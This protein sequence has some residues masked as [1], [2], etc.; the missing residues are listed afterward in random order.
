MVTG[1]DGG[2]WGPA[3]GESN[4]LLWT[5]N[6]D[7]SINTSPQVIGDYPRIVYL[8]AL[9]PN[10]RQVFAVDYN[11]ESIDVRSTQ[12]VL[13]NNIGDLN[14]IQSQ[15][16]DIPMQGAFGKFGRPCKCFSV[17]FS[18]NGRQIVAGF[19]LAGAALWDLWTLQEDY[20]FKG[21]RDSL[22]VPQARLI[23]DMSSA[24]LKNE[25]IS[26]ASFD[27]VI[28]QSLPP[29]VREWLLRGE[30]NVVIP[31]EESKKPKQSWFWKHWK[32]WKYWKRLMYDL[33]IIGQH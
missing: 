26:S 11:Y 29:Q 27:E 4:L 2:K 6:D 14:N 32:L 8:V 23:C 3:K 9:S 18:P 13:W 28:Y 25:D 21:L 5:I 24:L 12:P 17:A 31:R 30:D 15:S 1:C 16:I 19:E 33:W 7:G 22:G 10:G 20:V